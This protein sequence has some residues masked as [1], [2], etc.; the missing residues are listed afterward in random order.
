M[1]SN[2]RLGT[3]CQERIFLNSK[4]FSSVTAFPPQHS[5]GG[6][7]WGPEE[8]TEAKGGESCPLPLLS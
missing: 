3:V 2:L 1:G 7:N 5:L 4:L 6:G 8:P